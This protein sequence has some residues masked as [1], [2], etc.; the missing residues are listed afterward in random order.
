MIPATYHYW[1]TNAHVPE[2]LMVR[3][4]QGRSREWSKAEDCSAD[5]LLRVDIEILDGA[6]A[7]IATAGTLQSYNTPSVDLRGGV[8]FPCFVDLHT[9]LDKGQT[10][11]R[12]PNPDGS[13]DQA[14]QTIRRDAENHWHAEDVYQRM[15]FGL[16]CSYAHGSKA[17][18]THIDAAGEQADISFEVFKALREA[19]CDRLILQ[20]VCLVSLDYFFTPAGERLA[21]QV[22]ELGGILG[23]VAFM[24]PEIEEQ[25]DRVFKLAK[26]RNLNLDFHTDENNDPRSITLRYVAE[27]AIRYRYQGRVVC[28][29]CCS[30]AVQAPEE[31]DKTIALVKKVVWALS[32]CPS[33]IYFYKTANQN[34]PPAGVVLLYFTN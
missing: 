6:I 24:N 9:H 25:V 20:A 8:V 14:L 28:G 17:V 4:K 32:A 12:S 10:W 23:G 16:K 29:H 1:L 21:D 3:S 26:D 11:E 5:N 7:S 33:A 30:L 15:E 22:A 34:S 2:P 18:R 19:W 31:A 27:A 13:F